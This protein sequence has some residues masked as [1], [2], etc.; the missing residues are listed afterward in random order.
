MM[1]SFKI[2]K[3]KERVPFEV[4]V[5]PPLKTQKI[6]IIFIKKIHKP[7]I[8]VEFVYNDLGVSKII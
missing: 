6:P 7:K 3:R 1:K 5:I 4:T 2:T 8:F